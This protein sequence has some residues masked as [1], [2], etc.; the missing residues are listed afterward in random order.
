MLFFRGEGHYG[1]HHGSSVAKWQ[2]FF[3]QFDDNIHTKELA[4]SQATPARSMATIWDVQS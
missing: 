1:W 2:V 3:V 4:G